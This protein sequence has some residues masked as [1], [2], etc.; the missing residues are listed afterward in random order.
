MIV[1]IP[2]DIYAYK[3][4]LIGNFTLRQALFTVSAAIILFVIFIPLYAL[5]HDTSFAGFIASLVATCIMLAGRIEKDGLPFEK[6]LFLKLKSH[7]HPDKRPFEMT[8]L[9]ESIIADNEEM[10]KTDDSKN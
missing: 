4:K 9:Y 6:Y 10:E 7:C 5:T 2:E 3:P 8:N 1:R